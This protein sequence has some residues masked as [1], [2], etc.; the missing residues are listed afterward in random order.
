VSGTG[1]G[2]GDGGL[3][4]S[5]GVATGG[6]AVGSML[7]G[8]LVMAASLVVG[9]LEC[10]CETGAC[11]GGAGRRVTRVDTGTRIVAV[12]VAGTASLACQGEFSNLKGKH[13][14]SKWTCWEVRTCRDSGT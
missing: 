12:G 5:P 4:R 9:P 10:A 7:I 6:G 2:D 1:D 3:E 8:T 11:R 13:D 14:S